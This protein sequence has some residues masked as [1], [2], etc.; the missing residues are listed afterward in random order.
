MPTIAVAGASRGIGLELVRQFSAGGWRAIGTSREMAKGAA[1]SAAGGEVYLCDVV[2]AASVARLGQG[3]AKESIDILVCNAGI[4]G[5]RDWSLGNTDY[6]AWAQVMH[7]NLLAPMRVIE[8][9]VEPVARSSL[10]T[11]AL[12]SSRLGSIAQADGTGIIYR[13]SKAALN[14]LGNNLAVLLAARG[15]NVVML[16]PGW[17]RTDM[18]G[19]SASISVEESVAGMKKVLTGI[20]PADSGKFYSFDGSEIGW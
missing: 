11:I 9:L 3:L 8:A 12:M 4:Y 16:H 7:T 10:R 15:I 1:I 18:G 14:A 13:T 2:D 20:G 19:P 6:A 5:P 17:V